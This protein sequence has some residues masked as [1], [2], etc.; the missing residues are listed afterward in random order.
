MLSHRAASSPLADEALFIHLAYTRAVENEIFFLSL[1]P[2]RTPRRQQ[3]ILC[4]G[5]E[6]IPA[7]RKHP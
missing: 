6:R 7:R 2:G 4:G 1:Q 5:L 3:P